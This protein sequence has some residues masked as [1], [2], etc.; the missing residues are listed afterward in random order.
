[1]EQPNPP[2]KVASNDQLGLVERLRNT[3]NWMRESYG[4]WK[5]CV[6]KYDRAPFEAA[7]ELEVLMAQRNAISSALQKVLDAHSREA[8]AT[9]SYRNARENFSD[10]SSERKAQECAMLAAS[11]AEREARVLLLTLRA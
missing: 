2:A 1:M 10:S 9:L 3:P 11:D 8:K 5:D 7:D 6:L 4:S